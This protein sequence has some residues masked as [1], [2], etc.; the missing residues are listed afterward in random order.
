MSGRGEPGVNGGPPGDLYV[1]VQ[2]NPHDYYERE[3]DNIY[4]EL[5]LTFS[6]VA[7]GDDV[8]VPTVHGKIK[9]KVPAGTQ[10]GKT[11][12]LRGKG[13]P[14]VHGRGHGVQHIHDR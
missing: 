5:P 12:R 14:N 9:L 3:G 11:F 8:E 4:C 2:V 13:V 6:Q 10:T 7:L 1:V